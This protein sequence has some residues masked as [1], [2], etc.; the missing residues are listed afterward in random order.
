MFKLARDG[1][2]SYSMLIC[3]LESF[4]AVV[5]KHTYSFRK[6][7]YDVDNILV[8]AIVNSM[9]FSTNKITIMWIINL[10]KLRYVDVIF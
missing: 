3:D 4:K 10:F 5:R 2:I 7:I 8:K 9:S 1:S 6:R